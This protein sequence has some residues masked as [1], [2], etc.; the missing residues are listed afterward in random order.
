MVPGRRPLAV[1][2]NK[3]KLTCSDV[4]LQQLH[5]WRHQ[6]VMNGMDGPQPNDPPPAKAVLLD[7]YRSAR[8]NPIV[9]KHVSKMSGDGRKP[10]VPVQGHDTSR[11]SVDGNRDRDFSAS[12]LVADN[13]KADRSVPNT[14]FS[15]GHGAALKQPNDPLRLSS[16]SS[17]PPSIENA[18]NNDEVDTAA[19]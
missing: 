6:S 3:R 1:S 16:G 10:F 7:S 5:Q 12:C 11:I 4:D 17:R 14:N 15:Q 9:P 13:S 8:L 2:T 18:L 19:K